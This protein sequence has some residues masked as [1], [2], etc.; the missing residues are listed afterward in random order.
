MQKHR[1]N[2]KTNRRGITLLELMVVLVIL[3]TVAGMGVV[4]VLNQ[5]ERQRQQ[6]AR[7]EIRNLESAVRIFVAD[8]GRPPTTEEGLEALVRAP[9]T[10]ANPAAWAG[11]YEGRL[12]D[13]WGNPYR[14]VSP[15]E[16]D[17]SKRFEI[18]SMGGDGMSGTEDDIGTWEQR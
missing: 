11:Y 5:M 4:G 15:G 18:W 13:P 3:V 16:R 17:T 9:P 8:I 1:R 10:L 12:H 2:R 7:V 6:T 14:Y